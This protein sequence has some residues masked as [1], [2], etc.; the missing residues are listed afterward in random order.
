M[1]LTKYCMLPWTFM[2]I[3]AGGMMQCCAVSPD[4]DLGDFI[5]DYCEKE[6][7]ECDPFNSEGLQAIRN[8]ILTGNLR[9]MCRNCFFV[10]HTLITTDEMEK[11]LK[12]YL[13]ERYPERKIEEEDLTKIYA[14]DWMAISFTNR[15]NLSCI[16]CVQS[17]LKDK[18][19]YF[20]MD[21]PYEHTEAALDYFASLGIRRFSTCVEGEA[22][23]YK[24]WYETFSKFHKKY[25]DIKLRMTT[26]LNREY[27]D[28][29]IDLLTE[30]HLLDVSIDSIRP[31]IYSKI[32]VNGR[33]DV[34]M[35]N[36]DKIDARVKER[37]I[38]GP[39]ITLHT[40]LSSQTWTEL[41]ALAD[42]A[43]SRGYGIE[44]GKYE[45]R[46]NTKAYKEKLLC[47]VTELPHEVQRQVRDTIKRVSDKA[48]QLGCSF[49]N[50]GNLFG[51]LD[52]SVEENYNQFVPYNDNPILNAFYQQYKKG[53]KENY[54]GII[55]D[56]TNVS[57]E[58]IVFTTPNALELKDIP[59]CE[60]VVREIQVYKQGKCY[61][62]YQER[63]LLRYRKKLVIKD[64]VLSY[65]PTFISEDV[66]QVLLEVVD[67]N[68]QK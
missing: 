15:C 39:I 5:L 55:Y 14:Y 65:Q 4:T 22:T 28:E 40:V 57:Y 33:I 30:Y 67:W 1:K 47:P 6:P 49:G 52:A 56:D 62:R 46:M 63:V 11:R 36:L 16:Y 27:S 64:G 13:Q 2:Q 23:I 59:D 61:P 54:L 19:P 3:H 44:M 42:F 25:P 10:P 37:G 20:K 68:L 9:P 21:F 53:T 32:R 50:Q 8:G 48:K 24:H 38:K 35:R 17:E 60:V 51:V 66:D 58:G 26:N 31:E 12:T 7:G 34:L 43:F 18:N 41:E 45:E 29:E